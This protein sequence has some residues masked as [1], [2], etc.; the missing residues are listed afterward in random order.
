HEDVCSSVGVVADQVTGIAH[1]CD[2]STV[3]TD[4]VQRGRAWAIRSKGIGRLYAGRLKMDR[5]AIQIP[6]EHIKMLASFLPSGRFSPGLKS[7]HAPV[8]AHGS[9][10]DILGE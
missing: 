7:N 10:P 8:R 4:C 3:G 1:K 5:G 6:S 2:P 9:E